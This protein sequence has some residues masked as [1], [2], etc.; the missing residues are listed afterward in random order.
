VV[1][2]A[3]ISLI[4]PLSIVAIV[5]FYYVALFVEISEYMNIPIFSVSRN[6]YVDGVYDLC[7]YGHKKQFEN[8]LA[9]GNRLL[10]GVVSDA[11]VFKYKHKYP[12]MTTQ[13]RVTEVRALRMVTEVIE[14]CPCPAP[15]EWRQ[16]E[17]LAPTAP[18]LDEDFIKKYRIH[19]VAHGEEYLPEKMAK[20]AMDYYTIPRAMGICRALPRTP[21]IST[22]ELM[23]RM[24]D[25]V[26]EQDRIKPVEGSDPEVKKAEPSSESKNTSTEEAPVSK[27]KS[28]EAKPPTVDDAAKS[29]AVPV[30]K[31]PPRSTKKA[32]SK[33][34]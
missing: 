15:F 10:V 2:F 26:T 13:E 11:N 7:H 3:M 30:R 5:C 4:N 34:A 23:S 12:V 28:V 20:G 9:M 6:V 1:L 22:S 17:G 31:Q 32:S 33:V 21:G 29:A 16:N 25:R 8:A 19:V 14:D 27:P 18:I 24:K